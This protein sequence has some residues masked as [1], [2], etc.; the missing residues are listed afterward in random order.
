MKLALVLSGG[1]A[2]GLA[3]VGA[4]AA[5]QAENIP[6]DLI[7]GCS[8]GALVGGMYAQYPDVAEVRAKLDQFV[9]SPEFAGLGTSHLKRSSVEADDMLRQF[10]SGLK[11]WVMVN[12]I[13]RRI[14]LLKGERLERAIH[15]LIEPGYIEDTKIP[16]AC[17]ATDL[18][19]GE[20]VLFTEGDIRKAIVAS[21]TIPGYFPPV[22]H[23]NMLLV[24]G[25]VTY[26]LPIPQA[27]QLGADCV[28]AVDVHPF[29][30]R[31]TSFKNV[32]EIILRAK[33]I[34]ANQLSDE[35]QK[36]ADVLIQPPIRE[37]Y[38]Y[39]FDR[40]T[41]I[42]KAGEAATQLKIPEILQ[43]IDLLDRRERRRKLRLRSG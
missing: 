40:Y 24:D 5:L 33:T 41:E 39:E 42:V 31:E 6:I 22:V 13:A 30:Q 15:A 3:H 10:V 18:I 14:A 21:T 29:L 8:F 43:T 9:D 1:G 35:V 7:V 19:S 17:N 28:I 36:S 4:L 16:F 25:A 26:N 12:L 23:Q 38:W 34:T 20:T 27:L 37:Y 2:R 11:D 32:F